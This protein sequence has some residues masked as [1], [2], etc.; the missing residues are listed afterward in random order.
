MYLKKHPEKILKVLDNILEDSS[1]TEPISAF[2]VYNISLDIKRKQSL[3]HEQIEKG[4]K[5]WLE[6]KQNNPSSL[7]NEIDEIVKLSSYNYLS[8]DEEV[9]NVVKEQLGQ[10]YAREFRIW[11][12]D[13]IKTLKN[14]IDDEL[15]VNRFIELCNVENS[16]SL[17]DRALDSFSAKRRFLEELRE[18]IK[19]K[20]KE[21]IF[22]IQAEGKHITHGN[23]IY[24]FSDLMIDVRN[25]ILINKNNEKLQIVLTGQLVSFLMI[26]AD[27]E[28][29]LVSYSKINKFLKSR[30]DAVAELD[31]SKMRNLKSQLVKKLRNIEVSKEVQSNLITTGKRAYGFNR[32]IFK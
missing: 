22:Y 7:V 16:L 9:L 21:A 24:E 25:G 19:D 5:A 13:A 2:L 23:N 28:G 3:S 6:Y 27:N 29:A 18:K 20:L 32:T 15:I 14:C 17:Y 30:G 10:I 11:D 31:D 12:R 26:L 8:M 4:N 1:R